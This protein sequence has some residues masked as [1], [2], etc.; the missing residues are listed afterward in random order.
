[1]KKRFELY[2][3]ASAALKALDRFCAK[4]G[5]G[6]CPYSD[7]RQYMPYIPGEPTYHCAM[8]FLYDHPALMKVKIVKK[9]TQ[10]KKIQL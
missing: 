2:K 8:Y 1:M 10:I 3:T 7:D 4:K 6:N 5:C 9:F